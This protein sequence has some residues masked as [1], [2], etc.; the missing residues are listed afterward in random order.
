MQKVSNFIQDALF[1]PQSG[2]YRTK[3]PIGKT[4]DFIT[5]PEISQAFGETIAAY[6]LQLTTA[7]NSRI[8]LV[9][10]GLARAHCSSTF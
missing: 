6:L 4:S 9:E 1:N 8:A 3:N 7:R 5:A 2:Y 10:M